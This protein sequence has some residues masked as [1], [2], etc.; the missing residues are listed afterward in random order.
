MS[1]ANRFAEHLALRIREIEPISPLLKRFV[2]EAA[3]GGELPPAGPGA[4]LRLTLHG[5]GRKW[6]NAYSIV[7]APS[8]RS[9][10]AIIVRRVAQ[11]RGGSAFLHEAV[12][13]GDIVAAH[14]PGNLF[15]M[16]QIA[17]RHLMVSGGIGVTPFLAYMTALKQAQTGFEL[18]HFC[19][20]EEVPIFERIL[21]GFDASD[22]HIHPASTS[23]DLSG[24]L[25]TQPLGTHFYTCGP[26]GLMDLALA[27]ARDHGWPASKLHS[28]SFGSGH[29]GGVPFTAVLKRSGLE[30]SVREDQTLLEAIEEAGVEPACLCR[31]G[32]C[33]ECVTAVIEGEPDH[34]DHVLTAGDRASNHSIIIC[35]SR[36]KTNRIVLDL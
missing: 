26:E 22:I 1:G 34:R 21:R 31:G 10:L 29:V 23:F 2:F 18:H 13:A 32:A 6:K 28:E 25:T 30:V 24:T 5:E 4:H 17:R 12:K 16:S 9:H 8:D 20:D 19:R 33:G 35:V 36:A 15:P 14:E 3:D 7:S 11:S 27:A